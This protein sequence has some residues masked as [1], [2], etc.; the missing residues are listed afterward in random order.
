MTTPIPPSITTPDTVETSLG[1][2]RFADGLPDEATVQKVYDNLD[3]QRGV[4][5]FLNTMPGASINAIRDGLR[6]QGVDNQTLV[7]FENLMDSKS[8]FLTPN[9]ETVYLL[10]WLDL[11]EGP[12]VIE[13]PPDILGIVDDHWFRYVADLGNAGPD[14]G[15]GG[16]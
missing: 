15:K 13:T 14:K 12:M 7:I 11:K 6:G 3:R 10:G 4:E 1:T 9:T 5:V 2:L 8:L 16:K